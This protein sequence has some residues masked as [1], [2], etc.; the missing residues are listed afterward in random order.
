M[1][2]R[3]QPRISGDNANRKSTMEIVVSDQASELLRGYR[4]FWSAPGELDE[5]PSRERS[6]T[7]PDMAGGAWIATTLAAV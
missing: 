3:N 1:F 2:R 6:A 7:L 4:G 5:R